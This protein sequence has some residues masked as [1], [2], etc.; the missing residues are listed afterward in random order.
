MSNNPDS[1]SIS[2]NTDTSTTA[3]ATA[4][5]TV[6]AT[7]TTCSTD[8]NDVTPPTPKQEEKEEEFDEEGLN[9]K[10][11]D[12]ILYG[13][14]L[15]Q[16]ILA[17]ALTRAGKSVL[18]CDG[19]DFYGEKDAVFS[20]GSL[21]EWADGRISKSQQAGNSTGPRTGGDDNDTGEV[22]TKYEI[23]LNDEGT[24]SSIQ[25]HSQTEKG[26]SSSKYPLGEGM[27][28]VTPYGQGII[29][30]LPTV[31]TNA[32]SDN[33]NDDENVKEGK[34]YNS[35]AIQLKNW[36]LANGKS[37]IAYFGYHQN[38]INNNDDDNEI[39]PINMTKY[40]AQNHDIIPLTTFQFQNYILTQKRSFA[41]DLT[42]GL[43]YANGEEVT[44]LI[45]SGVS[46]YC[47]FKSL[48]GLY[49]FM[50]KSK[51]EMSKKSSSSLLRTRK[52]NNDEK[53]GK[54]GEDLFQL[55]KVPCS[56]SDVFQTKLLSPVE[57]RKLMKFLQIAM[58]Y[59]FAKSSVAQQQQEKNQPTNPNEGTNSSSS[60][61]ALEEEVVTSLNERQLQQGRSLYRPQNKSVST[62]DLE[63]LRE[64][65][66]EGMDFITY[67]ESE[68]KL[69]PRLRDIVIYAMS[70]ASSHT[71][72]REGDNSNNDNDDNASSSN[73]STLDGMNDLSRH[74]QSLGRYGGTAFL[75]PL[76]GAGELSQAFCRSAAVHG[77]TYLLR[78]AIS[79]VVFEENEKEDEGRCAVR[80]VLLD[81][82]CMDNDRSNDRSNTHPKEIFAQHV[83]IPQDAIKTSSAAS[84]TSSSK[85]VLRRISIIRGKLLLGD[86]DDNGSEQRHIV[87]IPPDTV[88]NQN[89]IHCIVFDETA[90]V[91]PY[92]RGG[93]FTTTVLHLTTIINQKNSTCKAN[94]DDD[95]VLLK[96][97]QSLIDKS[98]NET[99]KNYLEE[100]YHLS[101]SCNLNNSKPVQKQGLHICNQSG[102]SVTLQSAFMEASSIFKNIC[103]NCNFLK[104]SE[105]MDEKVKESKFGLTEDDNDAEKAAL[106]SAMDIV[107]S[108]VVSDEE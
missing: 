24:I 51:N 45:D 103:P 107:S 2:P 69:T 1:N 26:G 100:F 102:S 75:V 73:Y 88:G 34:K 56:K 63:R 18:H 50:K 82:P 93:E 14:G 95:D 53:N 76:Y 84:T 31:T 44:G 46:E 11:Y 57:K 81:P 72:K 68:H 86:A 12:V 99:G 17:S 3:N 33:D 85:R 39:E 79:K 96:T 71:G 55:S 15:S 59:A 4:T 106:E 92:Y 10:G 25:I 90:N 65:F 47:E 37:P 22:K 21:M 87:I 89:V 16:S 29:K 80:G 104:L 64:C 61:T 105:A 38:N 23:L 32:R 60:H 97:V 91:A 36:T 48:L 40:Y 35:L 54:N 6:T 78:R 77:G 83:V 8:N 62:S 101:F 30:S 7:A 94:E 20:L 27:D 74:L 52:K 41:L 98:H 13:T 9:K 67:L 66:D 19:N 42:P 70:L 5:A 28:V 58:D 108:T 49:L 43:L